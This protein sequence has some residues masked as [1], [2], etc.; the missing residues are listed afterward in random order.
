M[1][2]CVPVFP[3]L[4]M[5]LFRV[6]STGLGNLM[7]IWGRATVYAAE[8]GH[9]VAWPC[10]PQLHVGSWIRNEPDKR[11]Y[12]GV[13]RK[14]AD[15]VSRRSALRLPH[16]FEGEALTFESQPRSAALCFE[17]V[18]GNFG[19]LIG[20]H[21]LLWQRL[22]DVAWTDLQAVKARSAGRVAVCVRLG[23]FTQLGWATPVQWFVERLRQLRLF[24]PHVPVWVHSSG[25]D[26]ELEPLL[27]LPYVER[28]PQVG[29]TLEAIA[30]ISGSQLMIAT[31]GSTFYRWAAYLGAVPAIVH[32]V[33]RW[34]LPFWESLGAP[35]LA[36]YEKHEPTA[37]DWETFLSLS[38][39]AMLS[40]SRSMP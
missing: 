26:K 10:W 9:S 19:G 4:D 3:G 33:D 38:T 35:G 30:L 1:K 28:A 8:H 21:D 22:R 15:M 16:F 29:N 6:S 36:Y 2:V 37:K 18:D 11:L 32:A 34:H 12:A 13:F 24:F 25:L 14:P 5:G 20:H 31:G 17:Q 7:T 23:D 27:K 40:V 39:P